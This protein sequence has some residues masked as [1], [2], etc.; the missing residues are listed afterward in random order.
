MARR[1]TR[2]RRT[3]AQN[4]TVGTFNIKDKRGGYQPSSSP[5]IRNR[6]QD[7][8]IVKDG[9]PR[10][11]GGST[12]L[13]HYQHYASGD[14]RASRSSNVIKREQSSPPYTSPF[15][16]IS[17][18]EGVSPKSKPKAPRGGRKR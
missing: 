15:K 2:G 6:D 7:A 10:E 5:S 18:Q 3:V 1:P 11:T 16:D 8:P 17:R 9:R 13:G 4:N 14:P 12:G